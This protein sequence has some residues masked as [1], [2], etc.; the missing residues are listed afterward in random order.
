MKKNNLKPVAAAVGTSVAIALSASVNAADNPFQM[1][2]FGEGINVAGEA[3][4]MQGNKVM[5]NDETGFTYGGDQSAA[6]ANGKLATGKKDP[7]VCGTF[8][9]ETCSMKHLKK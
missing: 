5:I 1:V 3:M 6:Y 2:E 7:A 8:A 9:S 4:D